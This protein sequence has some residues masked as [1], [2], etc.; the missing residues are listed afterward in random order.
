MSNIIIG[1]WKLAV[2]VSDLQTG[3]QAG[4][5]PPCWHD[6]TTGKHARAEW[7]ERQEEGWNRY[8][9]LAKEFPRPYALFVLGD[10]IDGKGEK[11]GGQEQLIK[12]IPAQCAA[13][14]E[15]LKIWQARNIVM[16]LG[17]EYHVGADANW[18]EMIARELRIGDEDGWTPKRVVIK[19][20]AY[21][22]VDDVCFYLRHH[23][24][25]ATSPTGGYTQLAN[26]QIHNMLWAD[27]QE[28]PRADVILRGHVHRFR[29]I[30]D[31]QRQAM[32]CPSLQLSH[33][34]Y[35]RRFS[36]IVHWGILVFWVKGKQWELVKRLVRLKSNV[37]HELKLS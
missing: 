18:E 9:Q 32:T 34:E 36:G 27:L 11:S 24:S 8:G 26:E 22:R 28:A 23:T 37:H 6:P 30:D 13:S 15:C 35:G 19:R 17:T 25:T 3:H 21:P 4:L 14:A 33:T 7:G 31:G 12:Q 1:R 29:L 16:V 2:V 10:A 20:A 5:T